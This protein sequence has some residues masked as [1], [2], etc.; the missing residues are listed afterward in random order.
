M[1]ILSA[2]KQQNNSI[3]DLAALPQAMIMQMAQKKQI[4]EEM[5]API[6]ARKAELAEAFS[7]QQVL[8]KA[9]QTPPTVMEQLMAKNAEAENVVAP[10]TEEAG[11][12]QLPI[13][14]RSYA[15]GGIIAF[16]DGGEVDDYADNSYDER[17]RMSRMQS[18]G[19]PVEDLYAMLKR[20]AGKVKDMVPDFDAMKSKISAPTAEKKGG[21]KYEDMVISEAK[22]QGVN[23]QLALHVLYKETGNLSNPE[24]ARSKAGAMG[25][26]QLM[27]GTAK[28]LGVDPLN[29]MENIQ[30]GIAYLKK[31]YSKYQDPA[32]AAAAY[33]AGPGR[34]DK[35][36]RSDMG[37]AALPKETRNYIVG[38]AGGGEVRGFY[39]GDYVDPM[40][41]APVI[42]SPEMGSYQSIVPGSPE[43]L[44]ANKRITQ[45][46]FK[47]IK[48]KQEAAKAPAPKAK[49]EAKPDIQSIFDEHTKKQQAN[50]DRDIFAE[51]IA[52]N[53]VQREEMKKS[54]AEDKNLALL[55]AGL[56][57]MGGTSPY[58]FTNM[59]Q[60]A[61][62]GVEYL[63]A[64][65][66]KRAAELNALNKADT[67]ALYY[68]SETARKNQ[69]LRSLEAERAIDNLATY[70][71]KLRKNYFME[72]VAPT[73]KQLEA[74]ENARRNDPIY[75]RL[76]R[77][78]GVYSQA[79]SQKRTINFS[80]IG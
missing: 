35:A 58:A 36:L 53:A 68:G 7:R 14:E 20:G 21:H 28:E 25:P 39:E 27:P 75:N 32:L 19:T 9:G 55:A 22:K 13:P 17:L 29:P 50:V 60:G 48:N 80:S 56:G 74:Y 31:M 63:G 49:E 30:G 73:P 70:D 44:L 77:D 8:Q 64:S 54:S 61:M 47:E 45:E 26:M 3:D 38:L 42:T 15:G 1:S 41:S 62:K 46:Q 12:A 43:N 78:A 71:A 40:G 52:R 16:D 57:M 66:A 4:S 67:E 6:L 2:I 65:K 72:G 79:P 11:V 33:N 10:A 76:S 24:T 18:F 51:M 5:L 34:L 59:G 37:L 23:P 69:T